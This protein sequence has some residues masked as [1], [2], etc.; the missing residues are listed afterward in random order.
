MVQYI[1]ENA[2]SFGIG[3]T[4]IISTIILGI[5]FLLQAN[6]RKNQEKYASLVFA[7][8]LFLFSAA[9][10]IWTIRAAYLPRFALPMD[11]FPYWQGFWILYMLGITF[12]GMWGIFL[13][14]SHL[15][16]HRKWIVLVLFIPWILVTLDV[17]FLTNPLTT[18]IVCSALIHDFRPDPFV[19]LA[20]G[21]SLVFFSFLAIDYYY[22]QFKLQENKFSSFLTLFGLILILLGG[23]LDSKPIPICQVIT[24][25]RILM[26]IGFW[27]T[28]IGII[29][30]NPVPRPV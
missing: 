5:L 27:L 8:S 10:I 21:L 23:L 30:M 28:S 6:K 3:M 4:F 15:L 13:N 12:I 16:A 22:Q 25:G 2:I 20:T 18:E 17:L 26:L 7:L 24:L 29:K 19:I 1:A 11:F 14:Y 9:Q